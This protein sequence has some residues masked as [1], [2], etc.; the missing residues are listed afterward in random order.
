MGGGA[1]TVGDILSEAGHADRFMA[2]RAGIPAIPG[3]GEPGGGV[4]HNMRG[5]PSYAFS[6]RLV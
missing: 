3:L 4:V 1:T 5:D 2:V 6:P